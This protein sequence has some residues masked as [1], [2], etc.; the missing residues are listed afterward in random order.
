MYKVILIDDES[1]I[2]DGLKKVIDWK[3]FD[4]EVVDTAYNAEQGARV[5]RKHSPDILFSD[6]RMPDM[7]ALTM[8]AGLRSE[9][10]KMQITI[11]TGY[12]D[13]EYAQKS[14]RLGITRLLLKPSRME[15]IKEALT[16]MIENLKVLDTDSEEVQKEQ[17][18]SSNANSFIVSQALSFL[19]KNYAK[20]VTLQDIA[21]YCY[22]S[23]W[24]LS[25]LLHKHTNKSFYDLLNG[26]RIDAAKNLLKDPSLRI[27]D[28]GELVGY[29]DTGHFSR[30]FKK[31]EGKSANS[32]RNG[33]NIS[34]D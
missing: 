5:I 21:D 31:L 10:P 13:F 34:Q 20:K 1:I 16:T 25:K 17:D 2:V 4:C 9:F 7:D 19:D 26:A 22:V 3:S 33:L 27:G 18:N 14:V 29:A 28:I 12:Q 23:Q 8:L 30:I 24:H 32:Y 11:L 15:E 6:I